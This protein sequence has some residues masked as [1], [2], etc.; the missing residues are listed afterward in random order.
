MKEIVLTPS[1][2]YRE[3]TYNLITSKAFVFIDKIIASELNSIN[4][5]H[6]S[7][8]HSDPSGKCLDPIMIDVN[9]DPNQVKPVIDIQRKFKR[10]FKGEERLDWVIVKI[11]ASKI[12]NFKE[13]KL[14]YELKDA[15]KV[16]ITKQDW[17][18]YCR[19]VYLG[20]KEGI[21]KLE[22]LTPE[23][24]EIFKKSRYMK[25]YNELKTK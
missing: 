21:N 5:F 16:E 7:I 8:Q 2:P 14:R 19:A 25:L 10:K 22:D 12:K 3:V 18:N 24:Q 1:N 4:E 17:D 23:K 13:I 9:I 15:Y 20:I 11:D 6:I